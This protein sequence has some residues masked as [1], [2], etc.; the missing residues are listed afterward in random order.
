MR[1]TVLWAPTAERD[2]AAIW[3]EAA[4]RTAVASAADTIDALLREDAHLR[5][6]SRADNLR[7]L[8]APPLGVDLEVLPDDHTVYV[9]AVW[10]I[11]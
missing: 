1:Y 5:G 6:E 4:D 8:F 3:M 7:V 11:K 9:L 2:L 10:T